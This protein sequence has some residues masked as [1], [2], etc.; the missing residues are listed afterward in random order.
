MVRAREPSLRSDS[1][2]RVREHTLEPES[3]KNKGQP[4]S[5]LDTESASLKKPER[6]PNGAPRRQVPVSHPKG[7]PRRQVSHPK[8]KEHPGD[9]YCLQRELPENHSSERKQQTTRRNKTYPAADPQLPTP[10][11]LYRPPKG[12]GRVER[13]QICVDQPLETVRAEN[14]KLGA[15]SEQV[16]RNYK[17]FDRKKQSTTIV[18][19]NLR[20]ELTRD[21]S[22]IVCAQCR[23]EMEDRQE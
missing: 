8:E 12:K 23:L 16:E 5:L 11:G 6:H 10:N 13:K 7:A 3:K 15:E 1:T 14:D 17:R 4:P 22:R 2:A 18:D 19:R 9:T 21:A 20:C